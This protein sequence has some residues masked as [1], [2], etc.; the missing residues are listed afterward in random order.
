MSVANTSDL[1]VRFPDF[2]IDCIGWKV[3][4][5][6]RCGDKMWVRNDRVPMYC[7]KCAKIADV[8]A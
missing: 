2:G 6:G 5:C 3:V 8:T 4:E 7:W 1:S